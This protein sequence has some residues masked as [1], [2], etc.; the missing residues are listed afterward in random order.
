MVVTHRQLLT[1]IHTVKRACLTL[2]ITM[3]YGGRGDDETSS[4]LGSS[5]L[6]GIPVT[7]SPRFQM[8]VDLSAVEAL[9]NTPGPSLDAIDQWKVRFSGFF[10]PSLA[11]ITSNQLHFSTTATWS[12]RCWNSCG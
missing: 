6:D 11:L 5:Y 4:S 8:P 1:E 10:M 9:L 12:G 2:R 3:A 7:I